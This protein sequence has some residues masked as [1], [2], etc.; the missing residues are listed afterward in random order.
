VVNPKESNVS[1]ELIFILIL[2]AL[3]FLFLLGWCISLHNRLLNVGRELDGEK[4]IRRSLQ[5]EFWVHSS[6]MRQA[7][8]AL[9]MVKTSPSQGEWVK[10]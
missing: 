2:L 1:Y 8:K 3:G 6:D 4:D 9:G 10:Q 7:L 5:S